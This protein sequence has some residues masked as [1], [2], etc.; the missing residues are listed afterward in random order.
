MDKNDDTT[1]PSPAEDAG[2]EESPSSQES[3]DNQDRPTA[4]GPATDGGSQ[5]GPPPPQQGYAQPPYGDYR[6]APRLTRRT[7]DKVIGGVAGGVADY[8]GIDP[9]A[10]EALV[11]VVATV[12]GV[13]VAEP[14]VQGYAQLIDRDGS[15]SAF[16]QELRYEIPPDV[17]RGGR[18][19]LGFRVPSAVMVGPAIPTSMKFTL[20]L[21]GAPAVPSCSSIL[22]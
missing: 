20:T 22:S 4:E 15:I 10:S 1:Q 17:E 6:Q 19:T 18:H 7:H 5:A 21:L 9:D 8:F 2:K 16:F 14:V 12:P 3:S 11:D 13:A